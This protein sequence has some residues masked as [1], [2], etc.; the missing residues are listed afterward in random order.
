MQMHEVQ[1]S[2]PKLRLFAHQADDLPAFTHYKH[3]I[4]TGPLVIQQCSTWILTIGD[5]PVKPW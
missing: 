1:Y 2:N 3:N 4:N 5:L